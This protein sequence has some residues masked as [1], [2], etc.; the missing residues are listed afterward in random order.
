MLQGKR[1]LLLLLAAIT[2]ALT[3]GILAS[4]QYDF[5]ARQEEHQKNSAL[6][7]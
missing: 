1:W 3:V 7:I 5:S 6:S 2:V 4:P